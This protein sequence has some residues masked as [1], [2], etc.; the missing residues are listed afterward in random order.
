MSR[1]LLL[2]SSLEQFTG[3]ALDEFWQHQ[4]R[5]AGHVLPVW[6][7]YHTQ[8]LTP[9]NTDYAATV[10]GAGVPSS[11]LAFLASAGIVEHYSELLPLL[12]NEAMC[13]Q[14][15]RSRGIVLLP[16]F[17]LTGF[18]KVP[19]PVRRQIHR[20]LCQWTPPQ[21]KAPEVVFNKA[22]LLVRFCCG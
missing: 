22:R 6:D 11:Y 1:I 12:Q 18:E 4:V 14:A 16:D 8:L 15:Y 2:E 17:L 19:G 5:Q 20:F 3:V 21:A 9:S 13:L 10:A 7:E